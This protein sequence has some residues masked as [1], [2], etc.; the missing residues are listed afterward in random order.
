MTTRELRALIERIQHHY[1]A[2]HP[3]SISRQKLPADTEFGYTHLITRKGQQRVE[4]VLQSFEDEERWPREA[5]VDALQLFALEHEA[6]HAVQWRSEVQERGR[7]KTH[8]DEWG[9]IRAKLW[10]LL[11]SND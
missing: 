2:M 3:M 1:P 10:C 5:L 7:V 6:A 4:I 11:F 9:L 8:D